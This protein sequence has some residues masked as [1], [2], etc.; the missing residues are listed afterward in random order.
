MFKESFN[1]A[2]NLSRNVH[3]NGEMKINQI[4]AELRAK[5]SVTIIFSTAD[6]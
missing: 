1:V 3:I 5:G 2:E 6:K 4:V